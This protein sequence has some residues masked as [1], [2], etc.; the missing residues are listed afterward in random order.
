MAHKRLLI[1]F[2]KLMRAIMK[3]PHIP[4]GGKI[5]VTLGDWRQV[6]PVD[7][8][9]DSVLR[10]RSSGEAESFATS[11]FH[12]TILSSPLWSNFTV[13]KLTENIR[14]LH[15]S[16]FHRSLLRIGNGDVGPHVALSDIGV[17]STTDF[18]FAVSWL[19]ETLSSLPYDPV[20]CA[21]RA[22]IS[23]FNSD[24]D[25]VNEW[26]SA[27]LFSLWNVCPTVMRAVDSEVR[28]APDDV[29][30]RE[31]VPHAHQQGD[32][33]LNA[34]VDQNED[35]LLEVELAE[36]GNADLAD[37][38]DIPSDF[39]SGDLPVDFANA[40]ANSRL[41][42]DM[43]SPEVLKK[44]YFDGVPQF[45]L[46][47]VPGMVVMLLRNIDPSRRLMN[48]VRLE[49]VRVRRHVVIVKHI[50][51]ADEYVIPRIKFDVTVG[52]DKLHFTR[53]QV[54]LRLAYSTTIH[55]SQ[56]ATLDR[57]V[58]DL[59]NGV[60]DHGQLYVALSRVRSSSDLLILIAPGQEHVLNIVHRIILQVGGV[61]A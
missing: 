17:P 9:S 15:D 28:D 45:E 40:V 7:S 6:C 4:F 31:P 27:R 24:V 16:T 41:T 51:E 3:K 53:V 58:I 29:T 20:A 13:L 2:D 33:V 38:N 56:A 10:R 43:Y 52:A 50:G 37:D 35:R 22:Y 30:L 8:D 26:V 55:K 48:G 57:V 32:E 11:A 44:Q 34:H 5:V 61:I 1:A 47:L 21:K 23:P 36:V 59:R 25:T 18:D 42:A 46:P 60:F 12:T 49:V 54:P 19:F 39:R 14:Q